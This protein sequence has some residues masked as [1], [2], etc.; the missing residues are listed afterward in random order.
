MSSLYPIL[1]IF[2][3]PFTDEIWVRANTTLAPLTRPFCISWRD[4]I[5]N[6]AGLVRYRFTKTNPG[7]S[8]YTFSHS[9]METG[10]VLASTSLASKA[11]DS[12]QSDNKPA[13]LNGGRS[14][15]GFRSGRAV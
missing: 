13:R 4:G 15:N 8:A 7:S 14:G 10:Y 6:I 12:S 5:G 11:G 3:S 2:S 9:L 1:R